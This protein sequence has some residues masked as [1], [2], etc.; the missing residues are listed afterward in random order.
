MKRVLICEPN[1]STTFALSGALEFE[2]FEVL[3]AHNSENARFQIIMESPDFVLID[4]L[5]FDIRHM[6]IKDFIGQLKHIRP[7]TMFV[8]ISH[9]GVQRDV[10]DFEEMVADR[11][12]D[13]YILKPFNPTHVIEQLNNWSA[14]MTR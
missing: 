14:K 13:D 12:A 3:L 7:D 8:F 1:H 6:D 2:G 5:E 4:W 9:I 10:S 11:G